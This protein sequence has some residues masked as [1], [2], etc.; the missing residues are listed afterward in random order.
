V[1]D[2]P[3]ILSRILRRKAEEVAERISRVSLDAIR[4]QAEVAH[5]ARGFGAAI[6][7]RLENR[8]PAVIAEIKKASPSKGLLRRDFHADSLA[9]AYE[10]AG[11]TCLSVLTDK[12][13]FLGDE[14]D[15]ISAR[16]A[17]TLPILRKDFI[18]DAYQVFESRAIGADCILL[19]AAALDDES[20]RDL[21]MLASALGMDVLA[22]VHDRNDLART[23]R[24]GFT[25]IGINNRDLHNFETRI[26]TTLD[27]AKEVP[28][29]RLVVSESGIHARQDVERLRSRGVHAFLVGEAF[30]RAER[31]DQALRN[32]FAIEQPGKISAR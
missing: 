30:M 28:K 2:S 27:L 7:A 24:L 6:R 15:L 31:P 26:E 29:D 14:Q 21:G 25:L 20:L 17:C 8:L 11:A 23:L 19:I 13:F 18:I 1:H 5:P 3:D 32:L 22:E 16:A 9:R 4:K 12:D 10:S